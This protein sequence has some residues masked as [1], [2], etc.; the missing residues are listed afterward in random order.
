MPFKFMDVHGFVLKLVYHVALLRIAY[1]FIFVFKRNI[2]TSNFGNITESVTMS[3][4]GCV[5]LSRA[6]WME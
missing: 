4:C 3:V 2:I 1:V 5:A 6:V